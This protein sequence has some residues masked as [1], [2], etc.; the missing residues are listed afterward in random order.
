MMYCGGERGVYI[1]MGKAFVDTQRYMYVCVLYLNRLRD[2][3]A[4]LTTA[5]PFSVRVCQPHVLVL[6]FCVKYYRRAFIRFF[7]QVHVII[8][9]LP[10]NNIML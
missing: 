5:T 10:H 9:S 7:F 2:A 4:L 6:V 8:T 3:K 1:I